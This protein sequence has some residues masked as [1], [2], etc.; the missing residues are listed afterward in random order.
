MIQTLLPTWL[1]TTFGVDK[2]LEECEVLMISSFTPLQRA[3]EAGLFRSKWFDYRRLHPIQADYYFAGQYRELA[4]RW[5]EFTEGKASSRY[6]K[7][8]RTDFLASREKV[9]VNQLRR[10]AD[11]I[12]CEYRAF[13]EVLEGCLKELHK[14][15]GKYY[16]RPAQFLQLAKD[17]ELMNAIKRDFWLGDETFYAKDPFFS[18]ARFVGH[19][20]Q[21]AYENYLVSRVKRTVSNF[22]REL[23]LGTMMYKHNA[24]RI[25]KALQ[26]FGLTIVQ[27][28][29]RIFV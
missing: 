13:L 4:V 9:C 16:P 11:S 21:I 6:R 2:S 7:G 26:E 28:V 5:L 14:L 27:N 17:K 20:D 19:A 24:L 29:Q 12:G 3:N 1:Q 18:P 15:E 10:C 23:L 25:E 8:A 22:Q